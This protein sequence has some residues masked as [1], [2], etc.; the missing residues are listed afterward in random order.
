MKVPPASG[1]A[2][3]SLLVAPKTKSSIPSG[4]PATRA[5]RSLRRRTCKESANR[6]FQVAMQA[7]PQPVERLDEHVLVCHPLVWAFHRGAIR[8][9][10]G[11]NKMRA[12]WQRLF[13]GGPR[14][15]SRARTETGPAV[16]GERGS[17]AS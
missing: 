9:A 3:W 2:P 8:L 1:T 10:N 17:S 5:A 4:R 7:A 15:R 14:G 11:K 16:G 6:E 12:A 13:T